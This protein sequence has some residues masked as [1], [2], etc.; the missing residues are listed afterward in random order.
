MLV[1]TSFAQPKRLVRLRLPFS[2]VIVPLRPSQRV[3]ISRSVARGLESPHFRRYQHSL[4]V[5]RSQKGS[6][7]RRSTKVI[8]PS[9]S[10]G[11]KY[12]VVSPKAL[13]LRRSHK[14][15]HSPSVSKKNISVGL[16]E[17]RS[18]SVSK[19]LNIRRSQTV[20]TLRRSLDGLNLRRPQKD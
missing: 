11:F 7:L 19:G 5:C 2:R 9:A 13:Y 6:C 12:P 18:P 10:E 15:L 3:F 1:F 14:E 4:N 17:L 8:S 20:Y 16:K